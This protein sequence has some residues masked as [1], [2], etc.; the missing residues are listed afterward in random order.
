MRFIA[1]GIILV[2][3]AL[4]IYDTNMGSPLDSRQDAE[5]SAAIAHLSKRRLDKDSAR[6][7]KIWRR[8]GFRHSRFY[9]WITCM[10]ARK[11]WDF[12]F[13]AYTPILSHSHIFL[14][15]SFRDVETIGKASIIS[16]ELEH[17]RRH[18]SRILG[19]FPR[20]MD[21]ALAYRHQYDVYEQTG[22][23]PFELESSLVFWDMMIG[24]QSYTLPRFP[25]YA[26]KRDIL[27]A[28]DVLQKGG[29]NGDFPDN[30]DLL[31]SAGVSAGSR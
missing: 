18:E 30:A 1:Y 17:I 31:R 28:I 22:L 23:G 24:V 26:S 13:Y 19:G 27:W 3:A 16:H 25:E 15:E 7:M 10:A 21:E 6:A 8:N 20:S 4:L 2:V 5:I 11:K 9:D 29:I 12:A 14:G